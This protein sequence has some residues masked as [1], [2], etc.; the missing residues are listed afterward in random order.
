MWSQYEV[1]FYRGLKELSKSSAVVQILSAG[2]SEG[3]GT[4]KG[5]RMMQGGPGKVGPDDE[6]MFSK[7]EKNNLGLCAE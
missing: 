2:G 3:L 6:R 5:L 7:G 4:P 1:S